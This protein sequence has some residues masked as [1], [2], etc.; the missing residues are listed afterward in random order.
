MSLEAAIQENTA[1]VL[2]LANLI[3]TASK[4]T[5]IEEGA[6]QA[7]EVKLDKPKASKADKKQ[8]EEE[9]PEAG[10]AQTA[11]TAPSST[12]EDAASSTEEAQPAEPLP[13]YEDARAAAIK[14]S[15]TKGRKALEELLAK[16]DAANLSALKE[17][18]EKFAD[19]IADAQKA[20]SA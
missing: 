4:V 14:L 10:A 12:T 5:I 1:A 16:F 17:T 11:E 15:N 20:M 9:K 19:L 7:P 3:A 2:K 13:T 6:V 8:A 18:P